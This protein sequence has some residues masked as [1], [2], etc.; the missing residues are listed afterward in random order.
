MAVPFHRFDQYWHQ[1]PQQ[2]AANAV[3]CFPQYDQGLAYSLTV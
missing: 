3:R 2:F 1:C